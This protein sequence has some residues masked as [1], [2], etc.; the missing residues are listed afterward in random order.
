MLVVPLIVRKIIP[1]Y[2]LCPSRYHGIG[3]RVTQTLEPGTR[4]GRVYLKRVGELG[5][6]VSLP[7][8]GYVR[9]H[10]VYGVTGG[11]PF[12]HLNY[13]HAQP[14]VRLTDDGWIEVTTLVLSGD[15]LLMP[16]PFD[17]YSWEETT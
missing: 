9:G 2:E 12:W 1:A 13:S 10:D 7:A 16:S 11:F 6:F 5:Q 14:N 3:V 8:T 4:L 15:E 17:G